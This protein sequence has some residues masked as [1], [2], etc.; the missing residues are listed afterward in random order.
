MKKRITYLSAHRNAWVAAALI[1]IGSLL[2]VV[3]FFVIFSVIVPSDAK[4][5]PP[6]LM[7]IFA[8]FFYFLASY[9]CVYIGC[10]LYN[11]LA[12]R[13]GGFEYETD[14]V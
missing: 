11:W 13:Y 7:L 3:P 6:L 2:F 9:I 4:A 10:V 1:A 5:A 14:P 12:K 8:P